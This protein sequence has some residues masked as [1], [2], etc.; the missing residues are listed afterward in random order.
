[1][2]VDTKRI[3]QIA[4]D[5]LEAI[6]EDVTRKG[7]KDTPRRWARWWQE[8]IDYRDDNLGTTFEVV[9]LDQLVALTGV[10]V[11]SLCEHHLLPFYCDL[12]IA[13]LAH[14]RIIGISKLARI[15]RKHAQRLNV[16]EALVCSIADDVARYTHSQDVAV[17]ASGR[18]LC[19]TMRGIR[20]DAVMV[21]NEMRGKFASDVS[22]RME[23]LRMVEHNGT[24][25]L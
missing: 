25:S 1:M 6:G 14:D 15:A 2:K 5:L 11:W 18:H 19:M 20:A 12:T 24:S 17:I 7:L 10:R 9:K 22:L 13:Y 4:L 23:L 16:Q 8:F 21:S 3:E